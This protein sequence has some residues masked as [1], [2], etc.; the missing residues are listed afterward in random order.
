MDERVGR[1]DEEGPADGRVSEVG[2]CAPE[3]LGEDVWP[4]SGSIMVEVVIL[5]R[6]GVR[7][8]RQDVIGRGEYDVDYGLDGGWAIKERKIRKAQASQ[9]RK[10]VACGRMIE[11]AQMS[12]EDGQR[13]R[14]RYH[15]YT[16]SQADRLC[17]RL[18]FFTAG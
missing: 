18:A 1:A 3:V 11:M 7:L 6:G 13:E 4:R 8:E 17:H 9:D 12:R 10:R 15:Y 2:V 14:R 5:C 16:S